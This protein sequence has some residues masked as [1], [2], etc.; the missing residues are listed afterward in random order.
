MWSNGSRAI[1]SVAFGTALLF[2]GCGS[3]DDDG[4][5]GGGGSCKAACENGAQVCDQ[6][7]DGFVT[8][9]KSQCES[10]NASGD[11]SCLANASSCQEYSNCDTG[12]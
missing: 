11:F 10:G 2:T 4:G 6:F 8:A 3:S 9:C 7:G 5:G 1:L 12:G